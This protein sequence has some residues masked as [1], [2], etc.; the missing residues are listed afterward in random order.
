MIRTQIYITKS[1]QQALRVLSQRTGRPE[2]ELLREAVD[3][4]VAQ[5]GQADR[6]SLLEQAR[7]MWQDRTDLPDLF[8]LRREFDRLAPDHE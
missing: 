6:L 8:A 5:T 7:G 4:F 3:R 2:S 1:E